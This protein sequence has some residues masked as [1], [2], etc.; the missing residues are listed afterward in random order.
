MATPR[1][2]MR[3][4]K[5]VL[6]LKYAAGLSQR[7]IARSLNISTGAVSTYLTRAAVAGLS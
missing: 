1:I 2:S 3:E 6:R 7:Q 4:I 5:D